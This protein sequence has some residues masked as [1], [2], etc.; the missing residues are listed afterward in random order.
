MVD[1]PRSDDA[2][3]GRWFPAMGEPP[4][5]DIASNAERVGWYVWATA[6]LFEISG[7]WAVD[8]QEPARRLAYAG[9]SGRFSWH[10]SQLGERLPRLREVNVPDLIR[11]PGASGEAAMDRLAALPPAQRVDGIIAVV[12]EFDVILRVHAESASEVRDAPLIRTIDRVRRDL[13][14][15]DA[16]LRDIRHIST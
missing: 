7:A 14:E 16:D 10:S 6:R 8:E 1:A 5:A 13:A 2:P 12:R 3:D 9:I 11:A 4:A 15:V